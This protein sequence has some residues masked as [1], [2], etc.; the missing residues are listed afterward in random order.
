M[1]KKQLKEYLKENL[2][3]GFS[4]KIEILNK[5]IVYFHLYNNTCNNVCTIEIKFKNNYEKKRIYEAIVRLIDNFDFSFS[6][7]F[8]NLNDIYKLLGV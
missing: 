1:N 3:S 6:L 4:F 5:S 8:Y 2:L 7:T